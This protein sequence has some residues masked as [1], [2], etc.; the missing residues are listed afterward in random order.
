MKKTVLIT[1]A[2]R[3][4]GLSLTKEFLAHG[5]MVFAGVYAKIDDAQV[6]LIKGNENLYLID[7][8]ITDLDSVKKALASVRE[9]TQTLEIII[10][11]AAIIP[12]NENQTDK[13]SL[14]GE[15]DYD[16]ILDVINVNALG[17]IR[18]A[19]VFS[20]LLVNGE[21]KLLVNIS[22]EAGSLSNCYRD[23]WLGYCMSKTALNMA[24]LIMHN[25]LKKHKS[26]VLLF[27]PGYMQTY[28][29]GYQNIDAT[30]HPDFTAQN[31]YM[32]IEKLGDE[33]GEKPLF[34]DMFGNDAK[35]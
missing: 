11:S 35:W 10:N 28:M 27:E 5:Y 7:L 17:A 9:H 30:Y 4:L 3:G 21:K 19:N 32:Q 8:D 33:Q 12:Y 34:V 18:V 20:E 22:S 13:N 15:L 2:N 26:R 6:N 25:E 14:F 24:S 31:I 1:G 16:A 29:H 23:D